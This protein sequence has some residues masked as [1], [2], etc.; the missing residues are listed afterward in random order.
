M[1]LECPKCGAEKVTT[2]QL[3]RHHEPTE[4]ARTQ[5][6]FRCLAC[7]TQWITEDDWREINERG[8]EMNDRD[9]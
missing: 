2:I 6:A 9:R 3:P 4:P 7:D 5:P 8:Q 1:Q